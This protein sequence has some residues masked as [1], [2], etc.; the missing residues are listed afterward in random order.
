MPKG[1][2]I[3]RMYD[4]QEKIQNMHKSNQIDILRILKEDKVMFTENTNGIFFDIMTLKKP[5]LDKIM[6]LI[7]FCDNCDS[8]LNQRDTEQEELRN[9]I[10]NTSN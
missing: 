6:K 2:P 10:T 1:Y 8:Y 7:K 9:T 5:T 3:K 4:I